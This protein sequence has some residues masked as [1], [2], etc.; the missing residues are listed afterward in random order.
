[1]TGFQ[2][3]ALFIL[4]PIGRPRY[5]QGRVD[6]SQQRMDAK[7]LVSFAL[8][9]IPKNLLLEKLIFKPEARWKQFKMR[10]RLLALVSDHLPIKR[11]SSAN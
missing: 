3:Q 6:G 2:L 11:V 7:C 9:P 1:M 8:T 10:Q 4:A 5:E